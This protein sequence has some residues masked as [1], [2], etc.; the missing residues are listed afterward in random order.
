M[1]TS[2]HLYRGSEINED[3]ENPRNGGVASM[4][5]YRIAK[6]GAPNVAMS[7]SVSVLPL[8]WYNISCG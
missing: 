6:D 7:V 2:N 5:E 1:A 3:R 8:A 4:I